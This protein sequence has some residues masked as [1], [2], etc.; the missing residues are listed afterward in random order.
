MKRLAIYFSDP[1]PMGYPF[2][3]RYPYWETYQAI[4]KDIEK[5]KIE[6]YIVRGNS[7][8]GKGAFSHGWQIK[9][10]TLALVDQSIQVD[11]IFNR[12]DKNTIPAIYDC[13]IINHP[14]LDQICVDKVATARVFPDFSPKTRAINSYEEFVTTMKEWNLN[15]EEKIVLKK[16]FLTEGRG[17]HILPLKD[18]VGSLYEDWNDILV[19]EFIDSSLGVPD[20]V[21]ST[22][23]IRVTTINGEPAYAYVRVPPAGSLIANVARGG[24]MT[25]LALDRLPA[26]LLKL[27]EKIND[28]FAQYKPNIFGSDFFN[29]KDGF[30]LIEMNS[31]PAVLD[32]TVSSEQKEYDD[33]I[34]AMIVQALAK[35]NS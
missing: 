23:D 26:D 30:K 11:L 16:N 32:P 21:E 4:V 19:Q 8:L 3:S 22:H 20:I 6:V 2:N 34:V 12:D 9:N 10:G 1:E 7:Y 14:D 13:P 29:S 31:R 35:L 28:K 5:H 25:P 15:A 17:V 18:V 33:K 24:T 27:I